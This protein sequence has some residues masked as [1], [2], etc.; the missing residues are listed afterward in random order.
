MFISVNS[1]ISVKKYEKQIMIQVKTG[2]E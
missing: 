1:F 2:F